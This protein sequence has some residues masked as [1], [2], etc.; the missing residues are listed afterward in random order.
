MMYRCCDE[1]RR[2]E[3]AGHPP[4]NGIDYLEVVDR[5]LNDTDPLR[6]RTL[7]VSC[8]RPVSGLS[9]GN[10]RITGGERERDIK[11]EW[12]MP[13]TDVLAKP[14][15]PA[16]HDTRAVIAAVADTS[17]V[18]VARVAATGDYSTYTL[19]LVT[20]QDNDN[21]PA[22]FDPQ[23]SFI[24]FSFKVDC[25]SDFDCQ[26]VHYCPT[27]TPPPPDIN[28]LAKD[29]ASF[30]RLMLDRMALLGTTLAAEQRRGLRRRADR[31]AGLR[32]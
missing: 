20:S 22:N 12:A 11:I 30:R 26:P 10:L 16:E 15:T 23:L 28:Y 29:Y 19:K 31:V 27:E 2:Q 4:L 9:D 5:D 18:L 1:L 25:P 7:L 21:P 24:D 13:A 32:R 8:I 6:Q 3:V 14:D 17:R